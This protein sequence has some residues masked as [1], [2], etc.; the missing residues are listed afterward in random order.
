[1]PGIILSIFHL[2]NQESMISLNNFYFLLVYRG[3]EYDGSSTKDKFSHV[4]QSPTFQISP[5]EG[6][7]LTLGHTA[8]SSRV[9]SQMF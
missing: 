4:V 8:I 7:Y 6:M 9:E 2:L 5:R 3:P 1:M